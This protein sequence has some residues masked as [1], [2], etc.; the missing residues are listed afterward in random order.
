MTGALVTMRL[1]P[2]LWTTLDFPSIYGTTFY[3]LVMYRQELL[4]HRFICFL[5]S[6]LALPFAV[7]NRLILS[8]HYKEHYIF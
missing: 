3:C 6:H 1:A 8:T 4:S 5:V 2:S 7:L